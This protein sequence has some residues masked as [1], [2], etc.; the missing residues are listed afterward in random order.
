MRLEE[1]KKKEAF[2]VCG[3]EDEDSGEIFIT[4]NWDDLTTYM[5]T[6][7]PGVDSSARVFHGIIYPAEFLPTSFNK[8]TVYLVYQNPDDE[9]EGFVSEAD[10]ESVGGVAED[11]ASI[12]E[13][14]GLNVFN[15][16][17]N[18]DDIYLL[19]GYQLQT[20]M[21]VDEDELDDQIIEACSEIV[22]NADQL[23]TS[24]QKQREEVYAAKKKKTSGD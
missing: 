14:G 15:S 16:E 4:D 2:I 20:C 7:S 21:S 13:G 19:Y 11:I 22:E 10:T 24:V 17:L 8:E 3:D 6:L 9:Q 18:I 12:I 23:A 5:K 1:L